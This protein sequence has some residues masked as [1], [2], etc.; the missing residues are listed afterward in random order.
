VL[1][2]VSKRDPENYQNSTGS[3]KSA[4]KTL[5][6]ILLQV[7]GKETYCLATCISLA[8]NV[9]LLSRDQLCFRQNGKVPLFTPWSEYSCTS[10]HS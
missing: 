10:T 2:K 6:Q 1:R 5:F 7:T 9:I 3:N 8:S 4:F